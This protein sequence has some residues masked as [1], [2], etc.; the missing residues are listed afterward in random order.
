MADAEA[1]LARLCDPDAKV[2]AHYFIHRGGRIVQLVD[3]AR[4]AWHAGVSYWRGETDMNSASLGIELDH[5]G[6]EADGSMAA[7]PEAQIAALIAL[8]QDIVT[9]HRHRPA[10]YSRP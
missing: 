7:F 1:A 4:R 9:R 8:L 2:S 6:H 10:P 3:E 5:K